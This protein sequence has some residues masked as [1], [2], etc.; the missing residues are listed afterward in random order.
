MYFLVF[1]KSHSK[2]NSVHRVLY[3]KIRL[4][5]ALGSAAIIM[6]FKRPKSFSLFLRWVSRDG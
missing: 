2:A 1:I 4:I 3:Y 6:R 5:P